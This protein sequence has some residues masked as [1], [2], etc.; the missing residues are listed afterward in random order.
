MRRLIRDRRL[1]AVV[2]GMVAAA[3]ALKLSPDVTPRLAPIGA[4]LQEAL[5]PLQRVTFR[6]SA[7]V[8]DAGGYLVDLPRLRRENERLRAQ[9][10][11]VDI[12]ESQLEELRQENRRLNELLGLKA[13]LDV[14]SRRLLAARV[15]GRNPDDWFSYVMIDCGKRDGVERGMVV[16]TAQG[17]VGRVTSVASHA[18]TVMLLTDPQSGVGARVQRES[19]QA[20]GVVLGQKGRGDLLK[21][22]FFL[23]DADVR[24]GDRIVTSSLGEV[25][26]SGIPIGIVTEVVD[27]EG[28]LVRE[29]WV[30]PLVAFNRLEEVLVLGAR[31][32]EGG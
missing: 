4:L 16:I 15:I 32:R 25:F 30:K 29:A 28:G 9:V 11:H 19:S 5:A 21:M 3:V 13:R 23:H 8:R 2:V 31:G 7:A 1:W 22:K 14:A 6:A 20:Q 10:E 12:L 27:G 18:A 24:R 26:P 17:L